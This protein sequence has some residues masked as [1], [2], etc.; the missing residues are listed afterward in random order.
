MRWAPTESNVPGV[1]CRYFLSRKAT[2]V[3]IGQIEL[4]PP[5]NVEERLYNC[6]MMRARSVIRDSILVVSEARFIVNVKV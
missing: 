3:T 1:V 4:N 6:L 5:G 2:D